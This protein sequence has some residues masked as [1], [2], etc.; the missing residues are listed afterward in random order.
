MT[1][2]YLNLLV[3]LEMRLNTCSYTKFNTIHVILGRGS[4]SF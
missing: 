1:F 4:L 2:D 3:E